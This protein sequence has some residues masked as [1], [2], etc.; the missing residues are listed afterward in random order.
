M[1]V[2]QKQTW[3]DMSHS[4][5]GHSLLHTEVTVQYQL[6]PY[7]QQDKEALLMSLESNSNM[8]CPA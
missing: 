7:K 6:F 5:L 4:L 2:G 8:C 3:H 1:L